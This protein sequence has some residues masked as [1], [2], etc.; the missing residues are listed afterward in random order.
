MA[1][2]STILET[3]Y[4]KTR[5]MTSPESCHWARFQ[6][7]EELVRKGRFLGPSPGTR[8]QRVWRWSLGIC[9]FNVPATLRILMQ[10][11][12]RGGK[13]SQPGACGLRNAG[14]SRF[15]SHTPVK[16]PKTHM[17]SCPLNILPLPDG[18]GGWAFPDSGNQT[19]LAASAC[20]AP[21]QVRSQGGSI[22]ARPQ[23]PIR[24]GGG[25]APSQGPSIGPLP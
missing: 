9:M 21:G 18:V 10:K 23:G 16:D 15:I 12:P 25:E 8:H 11:E 2:L 17:P 6:V 5:G 7:T 3:A 4:P 1:S 13:V 24:R 14:P 20:T 19:K 22:H